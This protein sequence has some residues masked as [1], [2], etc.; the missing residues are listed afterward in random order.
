MFKGIQLVKKLLV[1]DSQTH[2]NSLISLMQSSR[3]TRKQGENK[4]KV[5][6][7]IKLRNVSKGFDQNTP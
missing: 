2:D 7:S 5:S 6:R 1:N 4:H 3:T